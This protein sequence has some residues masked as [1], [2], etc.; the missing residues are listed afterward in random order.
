[1]Y[2]PHVPPYDS[3]S[4]ERF[5]I[6]QEGAVPPLGTGRHTIRIH[7]HYLGAYGHAGVV[8]VGIL[9]TKRGF[10]TDVLVEDTQGSNYWFY[11]EEN[12]SGRVAH[13]LE[14][15]IEGK[16]L[17]FYI[18]GQLRLTREL[19]DYP[20]GAK[21]H[22]DVSCYSG[23]AAGGLTYLRAEYE[24]AFAATLQLLM[25]LAPFMMVAFMLVA[26]VGALMSALRGWD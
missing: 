8:K 5:P 10:P 15:R 2:D 26:M 7:A 1:M 9:L 19:K 12:I 21:V 17:R 13:E 23:Y 22:V 24:D 4:S 20:D 6:V 18:D 16:T 14:Y 11:P 25:Q 3:C